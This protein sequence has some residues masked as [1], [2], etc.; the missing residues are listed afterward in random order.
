MYYL[1]SLQAHSIRKSA[2]PGRGPLRPAT[3]MDSSFAF[4]V[5]SS[6]RV[7]LEECEQVRTSTQ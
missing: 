4:V 3:A 2:R 1:C 5:V 6:A 7:A